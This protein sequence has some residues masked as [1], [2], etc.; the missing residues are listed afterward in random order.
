M[1]RILSRVFSFDDLNS[2]DLEK[3]IGND[4][5]KLREDLELVYGVYPPFDHNEYLAGNLAPVFFGSALYNF[6][7]QELLDAFVKVAPWPRAVQTEEREIDPEDDKFSG[8]VFKIHAN[9]D[10]NHR[11][12]IAFVKVCSGKFIR[13]NVYKL[14]RSGQNIQGLESNRIHGIAKRDH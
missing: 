6:G 14:V 2:P 13:N 3:H 4:A 9:I 5:K 11:S 10:P 12:R 7:I 1:F 8:F